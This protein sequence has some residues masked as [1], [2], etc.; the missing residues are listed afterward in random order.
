MGDLSNLALHTQTTRPWSLAEC[1]AAYAEHGIGGISVWR[2]LI[3]P[4]AGGV[5]PA[6]GARM[7]RDHGLR[8]PALVRGGFFVAGDAAGRAQSI[9]DNRRAIE[10]ARTLGAPHIVLVVGAVPE[11]SLAHARYM[12]M[13]ALTVLAP[14]AAA[15]GVRLGIEPLHPMYAADRSCVNTLATANEMCDEL[16]HDAIGV[17]IDA[18]HLWWEPGL[19]EQIARA[20]AAGRILGLHFADWRVPTRNLLTDRGIMGDGA[21]DL[22]GLRKTV[23]AAGFEGMHEVEIFSDEYWAMDPAEVVGRV[24]EGY[25][26]RVL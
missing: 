22:R 26:A 20:G 4:E 14:E 7:I 21:L 24:I 13:D 8:V 6:E 1:C 3:D 2:H 9:D 18:Y 5:D 10:E 11:I 16:N 19:E 15:A 23:E 12:V 25:R 17:V